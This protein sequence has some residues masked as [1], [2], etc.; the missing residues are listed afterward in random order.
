MVN[1][2]WLHY[3]LLSW[4][5]VVKGAAALCKA[6]PRGTFQ[7]GSVSAASTG[8]SQ[9]AEGGGNSYTLTTP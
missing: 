6:N 7:E 5:S 1:L 9:E 3:Y 2:L 8:A 4:I